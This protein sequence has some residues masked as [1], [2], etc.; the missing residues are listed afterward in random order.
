MVF[1]VK[2]CE[3]FFIPWANIVRKVQ[4]LKFKF[5][6]KSLK[7]TDLGPYAGPENHFTK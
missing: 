1:R 5:L 2:L 7:T 6:Q 4:I 3:L